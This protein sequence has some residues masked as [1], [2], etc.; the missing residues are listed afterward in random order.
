VELVDR[1]RQG[2]RRALARILTLLERQEPEARRLSA[3]LHRLAGPAHTVGVTGPPGAG[4]STLIARLVAALRQRPQTVAV[5]AIDPSSPL[6]GGALLGDRVRMT[7]LTG[8]P[9]VFVRSLAARGGRGG[10]ADVV[11]D[12]LTALAAAGFERILIETVG[13]GQDQVEV[14]D[15]VHTT[16]V[17]EPPGLGD[18]I[19]ALK[20][21][22]L[23]VA[24]LFV[25]N[26]ADR[27]GAAQTAAILRQM[28]RLG[29]RRPWE[30]PVL[31]TTAT[32]GQGVEAVVAALDQH[33]AH[34][35]RSG[36]WS[37]VEERRAASTI[38]RLAQRR[39]WRRLEAALPP[40]RWT[41]LVQAVA[42]RQTDPHHAADELLRALGLPPE[43]PPPD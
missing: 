13:A 29:P 10:L 43:E 38:R 8:D 26:K 36:E 21:G 14:A 7:D 2:D 27:E 28:L 6:T 20:A 40:D 32:T 33:R 37:R 35:L 9:G 5:V 16:L 30:P 25:V 17:V 23:E 11:G 15:L 34:L 3:A 18:E 1:L 42:A 19:Q 4:K 39:L 41:T 12:F 24:D 22:L 31:L